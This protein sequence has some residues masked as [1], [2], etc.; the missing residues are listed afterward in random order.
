MESGLASATALATVPKFSR[1][2]R[3]D[4]SI[5]AGDVYSSSEEAEIYGSRRLHGTIDVR[6]ESF[7]VQ[8]ESRCSLCKW[9]K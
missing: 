6:L 2:H 1:Q 3:S 9:R 8:H 4:Q 5:R 7:G